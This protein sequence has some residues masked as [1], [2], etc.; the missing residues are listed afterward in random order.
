MNLISLGKHLAAISLVVV[1]P[2]LPVTAT[3]AR[4]PEPP[5]VGQVPQGG[6]GV[7]DGNNGYCG[8]HPQGTARGA[9]AFHQHAGH[10]PVQGLGDK[11][12]A[13]VA[14]PGQGDEELA[15]WAVR[16]SV[17]TPQKLSHKPRCTRGAPGGGQDFG[18]GEAGSHQPWYSF[19]ASARLLPGR[20]MAALRAPDLIILMAFARHQDCVEEWA[21]RTARRMASR[22]SGTST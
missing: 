3:T 4:Q 5:G 1:L 16:E 2:Q 15:R 22:R 9:P 21:Q 11:L 7:I 17:L 19:S 8:G 18:D 10:A 13:V 20:R 6:E 14:L 12:V